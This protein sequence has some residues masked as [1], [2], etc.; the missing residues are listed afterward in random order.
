MAKDK[1]K[2]PPC[3]RCGSQETVALTIYGRPISGRYQCLTCEA[4]RPRTGPSYFGPEN[5]ADCGGTGEPIRDAPPLPAARGPAPVAEITALRAK[6]LAMTSDEL[7][8]EAFHAAA[9][10]D[11]ALYQRLLRSADP[12]RWRDRL[13]AVYAA[14][15]GN[16]AAVARRL[17]L[18]PPGLSKLVAGDDELRQAIAIRWPHAQRQVTRSN[19]GHTDQR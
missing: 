1:R 12:V 3:P 8:E 9:L 10:G 17:G 2:A 4:R 13:K 16:G 18:T 15:D 14:C 5:P 6:A 7:R 19:G 11:P